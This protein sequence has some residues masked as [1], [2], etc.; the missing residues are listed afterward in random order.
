MII[1]LLTNNDFAEQPNNRHRDGAGAVPQ[2]A[3]VPQTR[4]DP[5]DVV[6]HGCGAT[7]RSHALTPLTSFL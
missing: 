6:A 4:D 3:R 2:S 5:P 1:W 7:I